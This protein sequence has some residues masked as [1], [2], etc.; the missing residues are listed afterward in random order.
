MRWYESDDHPARHTE[1]SFLIHEVG[2]ELPL[3]QV[4]PELGLD[5]HEWTPVF[6]EAF[7]IGP[8]AVLMHGLRP[9]GHDGAQVQAR[10]TS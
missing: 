5:D 9:E 6:G 3:C 1:P 4:G 10:T 2:P 8:S 7:Q